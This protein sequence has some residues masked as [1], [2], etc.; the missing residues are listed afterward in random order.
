MTRPRTPVRD[1]AIGIGTAMG[2]LALFFFGTTGMIE[3][4]TMAVV[5]ASAIWFATVDPHRLVD[6]RGRPAPMLF[7]LAVVGC[8]L[9]LTA[10][11]ALRTLLEMIN[12]V[13]AMSGVTGGFVRALRFG[14]TMERA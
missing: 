1:L 12:V 11:L 7:G 3:V 4:A 5:A 9:L 2:S 6:T 10:V 8:M 13:V 14:W